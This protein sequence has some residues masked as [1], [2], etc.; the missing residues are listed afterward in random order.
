MFTTLRPIIPAHARPAA[1]VKIAISSRPHVTCQF[2]AS[3]FLDQA[4][5]SSRWHRFP[6]SSSNTS[7][8]AFHCY[9][10]WSTL[11]ASDGSRLAGSAGVFLVVFMIVSEMADATRTSGFTN[12]D[13][14]MP[15]KVLLPSATGR[16]FFS[17]RW[18][19]QSRIHLM[20]RS[21]L[22][23]KFLVSTPGSSSRLA[24]GE[25]RRSCGPIGPAT[26]LASRA[27]YM[28]CTVSARSLSQPL[29]HHG[30]RVNFV[31]HA[32]VDSGK[33]RGCRPAA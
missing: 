29:I 11:N 4:A 16:D 10:R 12:D 14:K 26:N 15:H 30:N 27:W 18:R 1:W 23:R 19:S 5:F 2:I 22:S 6:V 17:S 9:D 13:L 25:S 3:T 24:P 28:S 20:T 33:L 8:I 7:L 32:A 21:S 31:A